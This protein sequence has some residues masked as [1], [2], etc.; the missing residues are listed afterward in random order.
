MTGEGLAGELR[1][2]VGQDR[3][4]LDPDAG[5]A[6]GDVVDEAGGV[7][8]R[9]V[10][11]DQL[12]DPI[13]GGGVDGGELPDRP[14]ALES[15]DI[16]G[17]QGDQVTGPGGEVAE[18]ERP[19]LGRG[20]QDAGRGGGELGQGSHPLG[21]SAEPVAPQD[22][23]DAGGRQP[24]PAVGQVVDQT[25][26]ADGGA[27]HRLGEHRF[28]LVGWGRIRHHRRPPAFGDQRGQS[29]ALG[30]ADPAVVAGAGDTE[31]AAGLGH[32]GSGRPGPG[33]GHAGGR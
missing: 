22:L 12:A 30:A 18:P 32:A 28:D 24:H 29:V 16:E 13:A 6:L 26:S 31:G 15:A 3:A 17:V 27:G 21:P 2:V 7:P 1:A 19:I 33:P 14:D 25:P 11:G 23:L 8:G 20:G 10:P 4:K 9:L 5:Q